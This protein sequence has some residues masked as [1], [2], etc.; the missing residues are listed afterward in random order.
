MAEI[1][2]TTAPERRED[3]AVPEQRRDTAVPE[4]R[5]DD[6]TVPSVW[7]P[8]AGLE[9]FRRG[10][11]GSERWPSLFEP[12]SEDLFGAEQS[13]NAAN[14]FTQGLKG[15]YQEGRI[16]D[17]HQLVNEPYKPHPVMGHA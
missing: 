3:T 7:D 5:R 15:R 2:E 13:T 10:F 9:A 16:G 4:Q 17:D 6:A 14:Y 11:F 8:F 12:L 1:T